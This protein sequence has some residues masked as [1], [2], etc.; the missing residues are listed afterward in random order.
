[1][2]NQIYF[3]LVKDYFFYGISIKSFKIRFTA[4]GTFDAPSE[5]SA[6]DHAR[7]VV[8][9]SFPSN[10]IDIGK[11]GSFTQE[12]SGSD[13]GHTFFSYKWQNVTK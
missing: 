8:T 10:K 1:M 6:V 5:P 3:R 13:E 9:Y 7:R 11:M 4:E 12:E 2:G